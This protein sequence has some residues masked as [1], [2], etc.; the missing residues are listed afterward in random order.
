[1]CDFCGTENCPCHEFEGKEI[2]AENC[3]NTENPE[4]C[5]ACS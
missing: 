5:E 3:C 4:S 1:M 2:V